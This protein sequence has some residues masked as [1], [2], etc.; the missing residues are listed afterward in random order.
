MNHLFVLPHPLLDPFW[1]GLQIQFAA[2]H[3]LANPRRTSV[4]AT[5]ICLQIHAIAVGLAV[6]HVIRLTVR[7]FL[8][9]PEKLPVILSTQ[10]DLVALAASGASVAIEDAHQ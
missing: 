10:D 8:V 4:D 6:K 9:V 2:V 3:A 7:P 1:I 5:A